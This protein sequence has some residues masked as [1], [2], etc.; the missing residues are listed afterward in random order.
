MA[1]MFARRKLLLAKIETEY[2][3]DSV[4]TAALN[5]IRTVNFEADIYEA[6]VV[7]RELDKPVF[8][9]DPATMVIKRGV[10]RFG[11]EIAGAGEEGD[12]P[13]FGPLL[14]ACG[15]AQTINADVSVVYTPVDTG[16]PSLT[17]YYHH[18]GKLH[19]FVG[20]RGMVRVEGQ[21][22]QYGYF[23]FELRG[24]FV[25]V[26][27]VAL[28]ASP[29]FTAWQRPVPFRDSTIDAELFGQTLG[30]HR[31]TLNCGQDVQDYDHSEQDAVEIV[32]RIAA[33]ELNFEE[34]GAGGHD[35]FADVDDEETGAFTLQWGTEDGNIVDIEVPVHQITAISR[36]E[37]TSINTLETSGPAIPEPGTSP[38]YRITVR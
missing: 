16:V 30:L 20:A 27:E 1:R 4:P 12:V 38:D 35:F 26:T 14:R 34:P 28:P 22:R 8:G 25:P 31:F 17:V 11:V 18:D 3:E 2:A 32:D 23:R 29:V 15:H 9:A 33:L 37:D 24:L 5:A 10:L 13:A 19:K 36:G 21:K 7:S 6:T